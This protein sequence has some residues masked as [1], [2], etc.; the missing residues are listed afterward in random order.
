MYDLLDHLECQCPELQLY[1][2]LVT[3]KINKEIKG[4]LFLVAPFKVRQDF[5]FCPLFDE[6]FLQYKISAFGLEVI[7]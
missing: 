1:S 5:Y 4:Y 7:V 2:I 6:V 3:E